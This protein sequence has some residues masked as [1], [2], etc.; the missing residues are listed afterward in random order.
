M[1]DSSFSSKETDYQY[2]QQTNIKAQVNELL[3]KNPL[4][5]AKP[6]CKLLNL[7]YPKYKDYIDHI[8]SKWK[9]DYKNELGSKC[10]FH[11]AFGNA[12]VPLRLDRVGA[13]GVGWVLSRARNRPLIW[14]DTL[15]RLVWFE[16]DRVNVFVRK[17][18]SLGKAYQL[19][20]NSFSFTRLITDF[21]V[22]E[23]MLKSLK[24]KGAHAVFDTGERLPYKVIDLFKL[25]NGVKIKLGDLSHPTAVEVEFCY[26]LWAERNEQLLSEFLVLLK[27]ANGT[28]VPSHILSRIP[29]DVV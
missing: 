5:T 28:G 23:Q 1:T 11:C 12:R 25:S 13:C 20:C 27:N 6:L 17:P 2:S 4:L 22:L 14:K 7:P 19:L 18:A 9:T 8:R 16:T 24:F 29:S 15:G 3:K 26:P 10:S 21:V